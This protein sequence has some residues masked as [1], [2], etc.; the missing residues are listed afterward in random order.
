MDE[1][2]I[3]KLIYGYV[4]STDASEKERI[5]AEI[6]STA[7]KSGVF[8]ASIQ[9]FYE[10][11]GRGKFS[12]A[13]VPAINIRG[14]TYDVARAVFRAG[15]KGNTPLFVFEIARTE[16][17]YTEQKPQ[18]YSA[19][20]IAAAV[21]EGY[22]G[23]VFIQG[24]HF[25]VN[26]KKYH[27]D[28]AAEIKG[29]KDLILSALKAHFY[30]IDIDAS[31]MVDL[32]KTDLSAQQELNA[33][34]TADLTAFIRENEPKNVTVSVG[35]E[36]G[37]VGGKNSTVEDLE[38]FMSE[39]NKEL[40]K[41]KAG[42]KGISKISVQA[43]TSHGGVV[44]PDGSIAKVKL[45]FDTLQNLSKA[46]KT[47]Y[48]LSGVVQHGA[49]TLPEEAFDKFPEVDAAEVHLATGF[50]NILLDSLHFPKELRAEMYAYLSANMSKDREDGQT[51]EQF[52][53][54]TR[55]KIFGPF[56]KKMWDM[57]ENIKKAIMSELED[58]FYFMFSKL[59]VLDM[60]DKVKECF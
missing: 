37:E 14:M 18:E 47:K 36:I 16:I 35:G 31:T 44:L 34:I 15:I 46:A 40:K 27:A 48:G 41:R 5:F 55:K 56:K 13:T 24:D 7:E 9:K 19:A 38:T 20:I 10:A 53:Y 45:D 17:G 49:S 23:P 33:S 8:P 43:G 59:N 3:D 52:Y 39:Y 11:K 30:Q 2:K 26:T 50:Q 57:P 4:F 54:K 25:Q 6:V 28:A 42:I 12:N 29:L 32:S 22:T 51:D 1:Q 58:R 60:K 21:K